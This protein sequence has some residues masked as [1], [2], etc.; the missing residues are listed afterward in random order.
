MAET[1][2]FAGY[3]VNSWVAIVGPASL[4]RDIVVRLNAQLRRTLELPEI[5]EKLEGMGAE[6]VP[7][8]PQ[9][10]DAFVGQSQLENWGSQIRRRGYRTRMRHAHGAAGE[11]SASQ[12]GAPTALP[13]LQLSDL[14]ALENSSFWRFR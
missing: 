12:L 3:E 4:P 1:P 5:R 14:M 9:E 10:L 7:S 8:T 2:G 11:R 13:T 6:V